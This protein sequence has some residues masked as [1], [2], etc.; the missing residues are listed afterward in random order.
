MTVT[1]SYVSRWTTGW[2]HKSSY[3]RGAPAPLLFIFLSICLPTSGNKIGLNLVGVYTLFMHFSKIFKVKEG[4]L[5]TLK[6][7]F[8]VLS[9]ERREEAVDTFVY[10]NVS[11]EV[12]VLFKGY[13]GR[14]YVIGYNEVT[15]EHKKG[16]PAV[17]INQEHREVME[18]CLERISENGEVLLD[19]SL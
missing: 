15:G 13:D 2:Q 3:S 1:S 10:E 11:R 16:D 7:W 19:L 5:E 6:Q 4:K 14:D 17:K 8:E 9:S 18:Q 12:F